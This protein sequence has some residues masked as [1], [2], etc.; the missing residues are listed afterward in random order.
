MSYKIAVASSDEINIDQT[1]GSAQK[2]LI[3]EVE[4]LSYKKLEIRKVIS[5]E[6]EDN[7]KSEC[8][9]SNK[10]GEKR[11]SGNDDLSKKVEFISDSRCVICTKIGFN[12]LKQLERKAITPFDVSCSIDEALTKISKYFNMIDNHQSLRDISK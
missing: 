3:Y 11:C 5:E 2:F 12:A 1:F 9:S 8:G 7:N 10:C 4:G 6:K